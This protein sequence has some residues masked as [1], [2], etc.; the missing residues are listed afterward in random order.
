MSANSYPFLSR[1]EVLERLGEDPEFATECVK[2][3]Q[4]EAAFMASHKPAAAAL[5]KRITDGAPPT[6]VAAEASRLAARYTRTIARLLRDEAIANEP[7]LAAIGATFGVGPLALGT[8]S[9]AAPARPGPRADKPTPKAVRPAVSGDQASGPLPTRR[10]R[11]TGSKNKPK[12]AKVG[13][14]RRVPEREAA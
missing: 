3:I 5:L 1:A 13:R 7:A 4:S 8:R 14:P 10:G 2:M 9:A 11:P 6:A 12:V